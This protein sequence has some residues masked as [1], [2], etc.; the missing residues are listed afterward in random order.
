[1]HRFL[2]L[3]LLCIATT[4]LSAQEYSTKHYKIEHG[5]P[6]EFVKAIAQDSLG[7]LWIA[8]DEGF[9]KYNAARFETYRHVTHS[10]YTKGFYRTKNGRLLAFA[11]LDLFELKDVGDSVE[12]RSLVPVD[13]AVNDSSLSY[14]KLL[15]EDAKGSL[16]VSESQSVVKLNG[17][18]LKRYNFDLADRTPQFLR[19]FSFFE[20]GAN[21]YTVSAAGNVFKYDE[22]KDQFVKSDYKFPLQIE[23][24]EVIKNRLV[25]GALNGLYVADRDRDGNF[26]QPKLAFQINLVSYVSPLPHGNYFVATRG[27]DHFLVDSTFTQR[28]LAVSNVNDI[29]HVYVSRE[30]D[31]WLS[32]SEGILRMQ[33]AP[34]QGPVGK[35]NIFIESI[36]EDATNPQV[37]YYATRDELH[38]FNTQT[39]EDNL[40]LNN[41]KDGYFQ[42]IV[43]TKKGLWAANAFRVLFIDNNKVVKTFDFSDQRMFVTSIGK[44]RDENIWLT[45]PGRREVL[46]IDNDLRLHTFSNT[47]GG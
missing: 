12:F 15:Y 6:T 36:A 9:V 23:F 27:S 30:N 8:T 11:D 17:T 43:S 18:K 3:A 10:N 2:T 33:E 38:S 39:N 1:M 41:I 21:L 29:N 35:A 42:S 46:L 37:Y 40:I 28:R 34:F 5:L 25:I 14:P 26:S 13:R 20:D 31:I 16:W 22:Q 44:D 24:A 45:I 19:S 32:T 4:M 47:V 7:N